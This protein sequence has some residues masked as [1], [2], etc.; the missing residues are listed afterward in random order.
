[1]LGTYERGA[2]F[3]VAAVRRQ[4]AAHPTMLALGRR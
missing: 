3:F 4:S 1:V 2:L